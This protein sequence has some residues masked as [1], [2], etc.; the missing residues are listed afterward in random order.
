MKVTFSAASIC[1]VVLD[2]GWLA[3]VLYAQKVRRLLLS[4][5]TGSRPR[6]LTF[7]DSILTSYMKPFAFAEVVRFVIL[8]TETVFDRP[9]WLTRFAIT[10]ISLASDF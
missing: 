1:R 8:V 9:Y 5:G 4:I 2:G 6:N 7:V 3:R 10:V